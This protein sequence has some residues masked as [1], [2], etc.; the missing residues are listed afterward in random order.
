MRTLKQLK[1]YLKDLAVEIRSDKAKRKTLPNG[2]VPGLLRLRNDYRD[3]HIAYC[4]L[5][6]TPREKIEHN[7]DYIQSA[8]Y[9][10][11]KI[12]DDV[13]MEKETNAGEHHAA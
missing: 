7:I 11:C 6:G 2:Y 3:H 10:I 12:M 9:F 4:L 8:W 5:R 13:S 1:N